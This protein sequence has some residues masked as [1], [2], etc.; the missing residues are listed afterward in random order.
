[1]TDLKQNKEE[2]EEIIKCSRCGCLKKKSLY[3]IRENTGRFLKTCINCREK[4]KCDV[5]DCNYSC[6]TS[7]HL[8]RHIDAVHNHIK[9]IQCEF[10]NSK[11]ATNSHLKQHIKQIHTKIKDF[12]CNNEDCNF[13][14]ST[15]GDLERHIKAI[16]NQ[17]K[18]FECD[19]CNYKC[20]DN[21][22]L[23]RHIKQLHTKIKIFVC[24]IEGC[25]M[26]FVTNSDLQRHLKLCTGDRNISGGEFQVIKCLEEL[27]LYE[28]IDYIHDSTFSE[29]TNY[30][31]RRLRF[32]FRLIHHKIIIEFDGKQHF[33]PLSFG[34]IS[35]EQSSKNFK[36]IQVTDALKNEFCKKYNYKMI[37]ISY[38]QFPEIL[39]ILHTELLD[40]VELDDVK[41]YEISN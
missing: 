7:S 37:R 41:D 15:K 13:S 25:N 23:Q 20:S 2:L 21:S 10:C 18:N 27:G 1:M 6:S 39:S 19:N 8:H 3:K 32:D 34:S 9:K 24:N 14:C 35:E 38:K 11:Y 29:L 16:H 22:N 31:N 33:E 26:K 12:K 4:F 30:C 36:D 40:I 28:D 5:D 17:I